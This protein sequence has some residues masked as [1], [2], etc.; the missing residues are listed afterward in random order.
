MPL[1]GGA[2]EHWQDRALCA[3]TDPEVFFPHDKSPDG[4][5]KSVCLS[6]RVREQCLEYAL[7]HDERFGVWGGLSAR[8]RRLRRLEIRRWVT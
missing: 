1:A 6:C 3:T 8:E 4:D 5:A 7:E 2:V